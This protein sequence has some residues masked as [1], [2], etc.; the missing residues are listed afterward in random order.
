MSI[1][2]RIAALVAAVI[3]PLGFLLGALA[4]FGGPPMVVGAI[5]ALLVVWRFLPHFWRTVAMGA[6]AGL[7][8][9]VLVLGPG[10]RLAMRVV[11]ILD[12][13]RVPEF[14]IDGTFFI[15]IFVGAILGVFG[16]LSYAFFDRG[17]G[18]SRTVT[19]LLVSTLMMGFLLLD[20]GLRQE[21]FE[22]GVGPW[23]NIPM[24]GLVTFLYASLTGAIHARLQRRWATS[25]STE[26][27]EV[28]A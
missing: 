26:P 20:P 23:V 11:A 25:P 14:T 2:Q 6:L 18:A 7:I 19:S 21:L 1:T 27:V 15:M 8:A 16:G 12:P 13:V 4:G 28:P 3:I 10:F 5:A 22:L 9:G 24:F 17:L